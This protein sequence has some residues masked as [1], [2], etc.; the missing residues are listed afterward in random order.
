MGV[1]ARIFCNG[2]H[3]VSKPLHEQQV[4]TDSGCTVCCAAATGVLVDAVARAGGVS[5][6]AR[7]LWAGTRFCGTVAVLSVQRWQPAQQARC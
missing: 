1:S 3:H 7:G 4:V 2:N 6:N 5:C